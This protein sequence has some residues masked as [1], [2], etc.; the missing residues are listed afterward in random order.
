[1]QVMNAVSTCHKLGIIHRDIKP[2]NFLIG[3]DDKV[4]LCDFGLS[5]L[6]EDIFATGGEFTDTG[7]PRG[8][9]EYCPPEVFNKRFSFKSDVWSCGVL[10]YVMLMGEFPFQSREEIVN[11]Q[12]LDL[13]KLKKSA[14]KRNHD[15]NVLNLLS[16]MLCKSILVWWSTIILS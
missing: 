5:H 4:R 8:T 11:F 1:M 6:A 3:M 12:K 13:V 7:S 16:K 2:E 15:I 9:L 10:L 14:A